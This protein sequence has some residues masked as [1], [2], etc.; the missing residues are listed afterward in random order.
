MKLFAVIRKSIFIFLLAAIII[1]WAVLKS[2]VNVAEGVTQTVAKGYGKG[3]SYVSGIIP[4][5]S[6]TELLFVFL[7]FLVIFLIVLAIR[8]FIKFR[9]IKAV[10]KLLDIVIVVLAVIAT[11]SV[12]CEAAYNRK[13]M[14]LPYYQE[15]I[16]HDQFVPIYNYFANDLNACIDALEFEENGDV[17]SHKL[18]DI[19]K[20]VK[21]A[22]AIVKDNPYFYDHFGNV[23]PMLSSFIYREL[24][25]TGV[26]F[27]PLAE[28]NVNTMDTHANTPLTVGHELAHTKGVMREDDA[29]QL[30]FYVCLNS[31]SP[32]LRYAAY[33][34][35]FGQ[36][37]IM[38]SYL[39]DDEKPSLVKVNV[40]FNKT[41]N[42][43]YEY[44]K[45]HNLLGKVGDFFNN[46]YI[47]SSGVK[48]GTDSYSI[49]TDNYEY[50]NTVSELT[51]STY[52]SLFF[53]K[54]YR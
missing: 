30:S 4:G 5:V 9:P 10:C 21:A 8:D 50:D 39:K 28:A 16:K 35:H 17:K 7:L 23:K 48:E 53:E 15:V 54:Y 38:A 40:Q 45:K 29:N 11:Y 27:N 19:V 32:Y 22:Y 43:I 13:K 36:L 49:G 20:D 34:A 18:D 12:S 14:P 24:Q 26:T 52:Q 47:K 6:L 33:C 51:P 31:E 44:W 37:E 42:Y 2:N 25:I 46:L 41:R 1:A 3:L